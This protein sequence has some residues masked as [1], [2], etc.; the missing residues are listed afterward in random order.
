VRDKLL[1]LCVRD[2]VA[3]II[4]HL[5]KIC[6]SHKTLKKKLTYSL[7][8]P[9]YLNCHTI[10]YNK[11]RNQKLQDKH[12]YIEQSDVIK[13]FFFETYGV[14]SSFSSLASRL[15]I[16]FD[17]LGFIKL[18]HLFL[19]FD[20]Q[21]CYIF[22]LY[23]INNTDHVYSSWYNWKWLNFHIYRDHNTPLIIYNT[24]AILGATCANKDQQRQIAC[25][26]TINIFFL[27]L[28]QMSFSFIPFYMI[29]PVNAE[30]WIQKKNNKNA[31]V[32]SLYTTEV[33][34]ETLFCFNSG[35]Q[36]CWCRKK[37]YVVCI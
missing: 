6:T 31:R 1:Q 32:R 29:K 15:L 3:R 20:I 30:L 5:I 12:N 28:H 19:S 13:W 25:I 37:E 8:I 17:I 2:N 35:S 22:C 27:F 23:D 26:Y 16:K 36:F 10:S 24:I 9:K 21:D 34:E 11:T 7:K 33:K 14:Q 18:L 4:I